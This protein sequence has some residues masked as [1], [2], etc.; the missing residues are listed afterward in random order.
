MPVQFLSGGGGTSDV[1]TTFAAPTYNTGIFPVNVAT[2]QL[3]N[4][5]TIPANYFQVNDCL[6]FTTIIKKIASTNI[7][8]NKPITFTIRMGTTG[9]ASDTTIGRVSTAFIEYATVPEYCWNIT[10][11]ANIKTTGASGTCFTSFQTD[12]ATL[13]QV[14]FDLHGLKTINTT[15]PLYITVY[16]TITMGNGQSATLAPTASAISVGF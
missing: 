2:T 7:L 3:L 11:Y 8:T 12:N 1:R 14:G 10:G 15:V 4:T 5:F 6:S 16:A 13:Q 9:T